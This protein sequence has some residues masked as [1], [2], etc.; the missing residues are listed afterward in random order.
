[1]NSS[2][3]SVP[4]SVP[5]TEH[6]AHCR[7]VSWG[8]ILAGLSAALAFQVLFML[9]G[10]GLGFAIYSP[11]TDENPIADLGTGAAIVQGI[12]AVLSLWLGGWVAGR[13]TPVGVRA[14]SWL[15]GLSVWCAA[16][17]AGVLFVSAGAGWALGDLSKLVGGGLSMAGKP[18]AAATGGAADLAKDALKQSGDTLGSFTEEALSARPAGATAASTV[19]AKRELAAALGRVFSPSEQTSPE[20]RRK[21]L[22]AALVEHGGMNEADAGRLVGEWT[23]SYNRLKADLTAAKDAAALKAREAAEK[24][25]NALAIFSLC[26]FAGFLLGAFAATCGGCQGGQAASRC[27]LRVVTADV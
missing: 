14:S 24:A 21:A 13:F 12:S 19:R 20:E 7:T 27:E 9:L 1:M 11:L 18:L 6:R 22:V 15:H 10:A 3:V 23:A 2:S 4:T 17:V 5:L 25:A 26:A 8:A 16:T